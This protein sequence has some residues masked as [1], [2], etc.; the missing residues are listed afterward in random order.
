M[1]DVATYAL[2]LGDD[3]LVL[4]QRLTEWSS[5]APALEEDIALTNIGLDLLGQARALLTYAGELEGAGRSED[6]LAFL[7]SEREFLNCQLVEQP[8][9]DFAATIVRQLFFSTYQLALYRR[10]TDS[11]D[12]TLAAVATKAVKEVDYHRDHATGWTVRLGDGTEESHGRMQAALERLWPF[13]HELF[14]PDEVAGGVNPTTLRSEWDDHIALTLKEATLERPADG[15][16]PT[17]GRRGIHTDH[18]GFLLAE[19]QHL[20][21]SHPGAKW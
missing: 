19:M 16:K 21:R 15:W 12:P 3:A 1:N 6:D 18:L 10:L 13:T 9:S 7:R 4:A 11:T 5:R 2:C 20:H 8:N 17:G 14:E